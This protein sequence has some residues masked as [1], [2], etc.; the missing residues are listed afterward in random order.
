MIPTDTGERR[1]DLKAQLLARLHD[2]LQLRI[3][4]IGVALLAGYVGIYMPL[5]A[6]IAE[7]TGKLARERKLGELADGLERLQV[8]CGSFAKRLPP[9]ADSKEWMQYVYEGIR[10][11]PLRLFK[12]D[13]LAPRQVGPFQAIALQIEVEGTYF[14]L[15]QFL[16]WLE[17]NPRLF[18]TDDIDLALA[19][20]KD[21][22][23]TLV[24]KLTVL[25]MAG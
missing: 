14:D 16:R 8:Q 19:K 7:T 18:R 11:L 2:P 4:V 23:D 20:G 15:D 24:M 25:G 12:L 22:K 5:A 9:Q 17:S 6:R 21:N 1:T 10:R 13:A 3:C